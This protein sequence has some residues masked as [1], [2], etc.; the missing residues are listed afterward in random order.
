[1]AD[2]AVNGFN[3]STPCLRARSDEEV[4]AFGCRRLPNITEYL[5]ILISGIA[6][7]RRGPVVLGEV[8]RELPETTTLG[9]VG[10]SVVVPFGAC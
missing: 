3:F 2:S 9:T 10:E 5:S 1:M 8:V 7:S 4:L 6:T